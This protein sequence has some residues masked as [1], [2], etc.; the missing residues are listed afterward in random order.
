MSLPLRLIDRSPP[1]WAPPVRDRSCWWL[2][3][4]FQLFYLLTASGRLHTIDEYEAFYGTE[5][6]AVRGELS[7][8]PH[9][10]FFGRWGRDGKFY[11]PYGPLPSVFAVPGYL[12]GRWL[13]AAL[14][15]RPSLREDLLW[16]FT[17]VSSATAAAAA[18]LFFYLLGRR[19]GAP[20]G[21]ALLAAA[22]YGLAT[23]LWHYSTTFFSEPLSAAL[24][25]LAALLLC[26]SAEGGRFRALPLVLSGLPLGLLCFV[27]LTH[28]IYLPCFALAAFFLDR[29]PFRRRALSAAAHSFLPLCA[30]ALYLSWNLMRFGDALQPGYPEAFEGSRPPAAFDEPFYRGLYGLTLSPGKGLFIFALPVLVGLGL[31]REF[32]L[33][34]GPAGLLFLAL[35]AVPILFFCRYSYWEGGYSFGPRFLVPALGFWLLPLCFWGRR[36][37][38]A[39]AFYGAAACFSFLVQALGVAVSFL[40]CQVGRGYYGAGFR[41][42]LDYSALLETWGVLARYLRKALQGSF[43]TEPQGLGFDRWFLFLYKGGARE[44][45]LWGVAVALL[46]GL[47]F[48]VLRLWL[49]ERSRPPA[50]RQ[51]AFPAFADN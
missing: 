2:F 10:G 48:A 34:T 32:G 14:D 19:L 18:V 15:L 50:L 44:G 38:R 33:R 12:A 43:L 41:Y 6:L 35:P 16:L 28:A 36:P 17:Q 26:Q 5:S 8:P 29:G 51:E 22:V 3:L 21:S 7:L 46:L 11:S 27:R 39:C 47:G 49:S 20:P 4:S 1:P 40:E 31:A 30:L 45:W 24:L 25:L 9:L 23:P 37:A 13:G 42:N